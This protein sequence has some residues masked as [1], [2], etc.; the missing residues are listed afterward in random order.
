MK[1][2]GITED[3]IQYIIDS[4]YNE[5]IKNDKIPTPDVNQIKLDYDQLVDLVIKKIPKDDTEQIKKKL[6]ELEKKLKKKK[7]DEDTYIIEFIDAED[8]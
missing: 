7:K 8:S 1:K 3:T 4:I 2:I 5:I 6:E